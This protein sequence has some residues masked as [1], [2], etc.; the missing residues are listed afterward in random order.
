MKTLVV[1][2]LIGV[3]FTGCSWSKREQGM[4]AGAGAVLLLPTMI[5]NGK[6]LFGYESN[7]RPQQVNHYHYYDRG[8]DFC[9]R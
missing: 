3:L 9:P 6:R 1:A 2:L 8:C 7:Q 4:V 5:D